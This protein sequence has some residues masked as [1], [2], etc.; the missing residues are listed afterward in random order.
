MAG[1]IE[2]ERGFIMKH[3]KKSVL[4]V[5]MA[6]AI[7]L[8]AGS[9][10]GKTVVK[11]EASSLPV[12][13]SSEAEPEPEGNLNP[14]T[15]F[16]DLD[17]AMVGK[18]PVSFMI[19]NHHRSWPQRG[20]SQ[21][22]IIYELPVEGGLTRLMAI[23]ADYTKTPD[24][25]SNRSVRHDFVELS[26]P[27]NTIFVH[28]GGSTFGYNALRQ[29]G[30][31]DIDGMAYGEKYFYTDRSLRKDIEHTRFM[32]QENLQDALKGIGYK[33]DGE[34]PTAYRFAE[35][36]D[37]VSYTDS[38]K[39]IYVKVS[40]A[41]K[42]TF[43]YDDS[44]KDYTKREFDDDVIDG[45]TKEQVHI[46][47]VF[48][49]YD[50]I[51]LMSDGLHVDLSLSSG[52]GWYITNGTRTAIKWSKGDAKNPMAYTTESGETLTVNPGNSWVLFVP[53]NMK[54]NTTFDGGETAA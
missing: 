32:T 23:F 18:R 26:L 36:E 22:D 28:W 11:E 53:S 9:G 44:A 40:N 35:E 34:T 4:A 52:E 54:G 51:P 7:M 45:N 41:V 39:E 8:S 25:G 37:S 3:R 46:K 12:A 17:A 31:N 27:F 48:I 24:F 14:L 33:L 30:A 49:L 38:A 47:N 15:G 2:D 1:S 42:T 29:Y 6:S 5:L 10:C 50:N 21:A 13:V 16:R 43:Y 20:I 19:N